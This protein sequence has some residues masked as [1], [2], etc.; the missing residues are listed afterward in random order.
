MAIHCA[1]SLRCIIVFFSYISQNIH[2]QV[3]WKNVTLLSLNATTL[4]IQ[5]KYCTEKMYDLSLPES[6]FSVSDNKLPMVHFLLQHIPELNKN[7]RYNFQLLSLTICFF[8][9]NIL[10]FLKVGWFN[11][12]EKVCFYLRVWLYL[13]Y[14]VSAVIKT[15]RCQA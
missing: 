14:H 10:D 6:H 2:H 7:K 9:W 11:F 3:S 15:S 1:L 5:I 8:L 12:T 4:C 13:T